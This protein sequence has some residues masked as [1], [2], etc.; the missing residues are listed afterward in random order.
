MRNCIYIGGH[1]YAGDYMLDP[2]DDPE[3]DGED[4]REKEVCLVD[5]VTTFDGRLMVR[6]MEVTVDTETKARTGYGRRFLSAVR[7]R[8]GY[9]NAPYDDA[10]VWFREEARK[11][12]THPRLRAQ[13]E[14][15]FG[16]MRGTK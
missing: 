12:K 10:I 1:K 13:F 5:R 8:N 15:E 3:D 7:C 11:G 9:G 2:P 4:A 14:A 16:P 6:Y